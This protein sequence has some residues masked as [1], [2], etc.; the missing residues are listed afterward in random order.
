MRKME[1]SAKSPALRGLTPTDNALEINIKQSH[2]VAI[3]WENC[4]TGN[5]TQLNL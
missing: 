2:Y 5:P 3:M 1:K 4:V